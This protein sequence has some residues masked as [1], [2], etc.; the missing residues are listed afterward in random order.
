MKFE[1]GKRAPEGRR[2]VDNV[3][4]H[5]LVNALANAVINAQD[6]V[7]RYQTSNISRYFDEHSRPRRIDIAV[8]SL[9]SDAKAGE[10]DLLGVP[11]LALV[12]ATPLAIKDVEVSLEV[13]LGSLTSLKGEKTEK[14]VQGAKGEDASEPDAGSVSWGARPPEEAVMRDFAAL[15]TPDA[16]PLAKVTLSAESQEPT[17]GM[18]RLLLE[19]NKR[20]GIRG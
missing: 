1:P 8:P 11:I 19:L 7:E 20:I 13:R 4:L 3:T 10:E 15:R 5:D 2:L 17:E 6:Q 12:K 14:P 9:R 18:A 16:A